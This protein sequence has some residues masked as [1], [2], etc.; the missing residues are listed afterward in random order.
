[1][2][3]PAD[4]DR[5]AAIIRMIA[6][7]QSYRSTE[8]DKAMASAYQA[9]VDHLGALAYRL[10]QREPPKVI[11]MAP[12]PIPPLAPVRVTVRTSRSKRR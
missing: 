6:D 1:M 2:P 7:L 4:V 8:R 11:G 9:A 3:R 10:N 5:I 12:E